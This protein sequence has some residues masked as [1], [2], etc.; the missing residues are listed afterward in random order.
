MFVL[1]WCNLEKI[2]RA[3]PWVSKKRPYQ[4]SISWCLLSVSALPGIQ[5]LTIKSLAP[6][7]AQVAQARNMSIGEHRHCCVTLISK[8]KALYGKKTY[9]FR[10]LRKWKD[11]NKRQLTLHKMCVNTS[12]LCGPW[13]DLWPSYGLYSKR[14][15][16]YWLGT[17]GKRPNGSIR[18]SST[19]NG[20]KFAPM[21]PVASKSRLGN[22]R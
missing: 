21:A 13:T 3:L 5:W 16:L 1:R 22:R 11:F 8:Y 4:L 14:F 2:I 19:E 18:D 10:N 15:S 17:P 6:S 7:I 9:R 12:L 20:R